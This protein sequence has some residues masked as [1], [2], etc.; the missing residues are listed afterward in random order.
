MTVV[1]QEDT[2]LEVIDGNSVNTLDSKTGCSLLHV[3]PLA[4]LFDQCNE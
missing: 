4:H 3:T 2:R 1:S